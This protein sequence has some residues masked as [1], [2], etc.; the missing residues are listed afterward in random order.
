[1]LG[2][3]RGRRGRGQGL[4]HAGQVKDKGK[5]LTFEEDFDFESANA[6]FDKLALEE[7]FKESV[8]LN[9]KE[10]NEESLEEGEIPE[11]PSQGD[12][13]MSSF[14]DKISCETHNP[15]SRRYVCVN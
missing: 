11:S 6:K 2:A 4:S 5:S 9:E 14:F 3:F 15:E 10:V 12:D 8:S 7:Q 13:S 1:M